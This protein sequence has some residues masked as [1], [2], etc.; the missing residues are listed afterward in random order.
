MARRG[1]PEYCRSSWGGGWG[2]LRSCRALRPAR[3]AVCL[4]DCGFPPEYCPWGGKWATCR[5][6]LAAEHPE[7]LAAMLA[8]REV[9]PDAAPAAAVAAGSDAA[10]GDGGDVADLAARTAA[11]A[12]D[13]AAG[14]GGAA[15]PKAAA[16]AAKRPGV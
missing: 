1:P 2:W 11:V 8:A 9:K 3:R 16:A 6:M 14:A 13:G 12:L 5:P 10:G 15:A 7:L 4:A